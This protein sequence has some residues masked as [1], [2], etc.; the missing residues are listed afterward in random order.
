M[1]E[2]EVL[3]YHSSSKSVTVKII[4]AEQSEFLQEGITH[5]LLSMRQERC[6]CQ[7][8][9]T[10]LEQFFSTQY[11]GHVLSSENTHKTGFACI[12]K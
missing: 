7:C 12:V 1:Q 4:T 8:V 11:C 9:S 5:S 6:T 3:Q 10:K 2:A